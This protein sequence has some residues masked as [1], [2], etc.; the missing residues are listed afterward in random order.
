M[1]SNP[2]SGTPFQTSNLPP[3]VGRTFFVLFLS[4]L[5]LLIGAGAGQANGIPV[6]IFLDHVPV[7]TTWTAADGGRGVAVVSA[8]DEQVRVMAQNL[9]APPDGVGYFA[10]LERVGGSFLPVGPLLYQS[11][12]TASLDQEMPN[13]PYSESFSWV[14]ISLEAPHSI[15]SRPSADIALAGRLPNAEALPLAGGDTPQLL[16]VTGTQTQS[17]TSGMPV[18]L[19]IVL[20]C[21]IGLLGT[22]RL[23]GQ[24][25][26]ANPSRIRSVDHRK[27]EARQ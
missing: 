13:L 16:P 5:F 2:T 15:G 25:K 11:D 17:A 9:P 21:A 26:K 20:L 23:H 22:L 19:I 3:L 4:L 24:G 12:G 18:V 6:Q 7:K 27:P 10:W 14:L 1:Q 8:N